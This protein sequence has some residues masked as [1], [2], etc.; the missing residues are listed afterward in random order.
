MSLADKTKL[1][2][3]P[4]NEE[5]QTA[6]NA[7]GD[8][9]ACDI[10]AAG[11]EIDLKSG[12]TSLSQVY[13]PFATAQADGLMS[14]SDYAKLAALPT[15][16]ALTAALNGKQDTLTFDSVPTQGSEN[17]VTSG[18]LYNVLGDIESILD[19]ILGN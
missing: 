11:Y 10:T 6:L 13:I 8:A 2:A 17:P 7:K 3:L 19:N 4:T 14:A 18:G 1:D 12:N 16:A 5:L 9:L 15:N